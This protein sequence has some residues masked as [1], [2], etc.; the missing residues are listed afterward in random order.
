M[1]GIISCISYIVLQCRY[2]QMLDILYEYHSSAT[3]YDIILKMREAGIQIT[4]TDYLNAI[5][6]CTVDKNAYKTAISLWNMML[7]DG[8][9]P[10][11]V[12]YELLMN[13]C[14]RSEAI[15]EAEQLFEVIRNKGLKPTV[16]TYN[17]LMTGYKRT[18]S[19]ER[20]LQMYQI[21]KLDGIEADGVTYTILLDLLFSTNKKEY[22]TTIVTDIQKGCNY[23]QQMS[24]QLNEKYPSHVMDSIHLYNC[25]EFLAQFDSIVKDDSIADLHTGYTQLFLRKNYIN[26]LLRWFID[27]DNRFAVLYLYK[28]TQRSKK[29]QPN[30]LT[31]KLLFHYCGIK[32]DTKLFESIMN[33]MVAQ[34]ISYNVC[35][36]IIVA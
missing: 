25:D 4:S 13:C 32:Q 36:S 24:D 33:N 1:I 6:V 22:C 26:A 23:I 12:D 20:A 34:G 7:S 30:D 16:W 5:R 27:Q 11:R 29:S 17:I 31:Y 10:T 18:H 8:T 21:M 2:V 35:E 9:V 3:A 14:I 19:W 28:A 15:V